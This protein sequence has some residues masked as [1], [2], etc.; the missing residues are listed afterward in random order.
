MVGRKVISQPVNRARIRQAL[1]GEDQN[2]QESFWGG[3][4][5]SGDVCDPVS[6]SSR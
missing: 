5:H 6:V 2:I 3:L 1:P 4:K